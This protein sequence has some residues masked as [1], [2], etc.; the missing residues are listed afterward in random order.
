M[1]LESVLIQVANGGQQPMTR[2]IIGFAALVGIIGVIAYLISLRN[3]ARHS[4]K[5]VEAGKI[6]AGIIFS[7][8]LISLEAQMNTGGA[9]LGFGDVSFGPVSYASESTFGMGAS[10]V[11]AVLGIVRVLGAYFFYKGVK[12]LK[13]SFLEGHTE[14]SASGQRGAS[15]VKIIC[16]LFLIFD[17]QTL[18]S[19]QS[20]LNLHW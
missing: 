5:G 1:D 8:C 18:D 14:L 7:V 3:K 16:G 15:L 9:T 20:T 12:G 10:A 6:F 4:T 13:D 17:T 2:L 11:N 19:L